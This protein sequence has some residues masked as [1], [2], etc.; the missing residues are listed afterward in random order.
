MDVLGFDANLVAS[1]YRG[2]EVVLYEI[3]G[4]W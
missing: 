3:A 1:S 4:S 2:F